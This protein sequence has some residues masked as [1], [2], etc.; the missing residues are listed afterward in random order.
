[1]TT[2]EGTNRFGAV[3][4]RGLM[5]VALA[6]GLLGLS[7]PAPSAAAAPA[8]ACELGTISADARHDAAKATVRV[9]PRAELTAPAGHDDASYP[10]PPILTAATDLAPAFI[11]R[12]AAAT[13]AAD[14]APPVRAGASQPRAPPASSL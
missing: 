12:L 11:E 10:T 9:Q 7:A 1:V 6:A 8:A 3:L 14:P 2:S 4:R 5:A 13:P